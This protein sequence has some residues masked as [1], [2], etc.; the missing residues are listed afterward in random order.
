LPKVWF[1]LSLVAAAMGPEVVR[2]IDAIP[3]H[4]AGRFRDPAGA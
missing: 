3:A 2:S 4:V 1:A